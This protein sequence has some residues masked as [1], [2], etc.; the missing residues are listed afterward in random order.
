MNVLVSYEDVTARVQGA[1]EAGHDRPRRGRA[2]GA[3]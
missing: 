3:R 1:V 2:R